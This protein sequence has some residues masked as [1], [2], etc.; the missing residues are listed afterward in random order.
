M[1]FNGTKGEWVLNNNHSSETIVDITCGNFESGDWATITCY[2]A[3]DEKTQIANAKLISNAPKMFEILKNLL[4]L[5][6]QDM[7]AL[8][9]D[10]KKML[11]EITKET[12]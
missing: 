9:P 7:D 4:E 2:N 1:K 11:E 6:S 10:I 5:P 12:V 3:K 8:I